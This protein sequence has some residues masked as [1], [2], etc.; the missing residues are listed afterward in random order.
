MIAHPLRPS[1]ALALTCLLANLLFFLNIAVPQ[2]HLWGSYLLPIVPI[3]LWGRRRDHPARWL[4]NGLTKGY[5]LLTRLFATI[6]EFR[7]HPFFPCAKLWISSTMPYICADC[8]I[9][10]LTR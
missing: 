4:A 9:Y 8:E 10:W 2:T 3:F 5:M 7:L 6:H 1:Y